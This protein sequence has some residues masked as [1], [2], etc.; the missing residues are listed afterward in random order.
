MAGATVIVDRTQGVLKVLELLGEAQDEVEAIRQDM[1]TG[2]PGI[3]TQV[4][5][6]MQGWSDDVLLNL[7]AITEDIVRIRE[8]VTGS[9]FEHEQRLVEAFRDA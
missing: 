5:W 7:G 3:D 4:R 1:G 9:V 2:E 8:L 6:L